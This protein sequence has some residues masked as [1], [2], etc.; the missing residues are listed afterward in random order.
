MRLECRLIKHEEYAEAKRLWAICFPEDGDAFIDYY[1]AKRTDP[2]HIYGAFGGSKMLCMMHI[3]PQLLK[4]NCETKPV[5]LIAGIG[6]L[7]EF[8]RKGVCRELFSHIFS[9]LYKKGYTALL[10]QPF[11]VDFYRQFGFEPFVRHQRVSFSSKAVAPISSPCPLSPGE[12]FSLYSSH[13]VEK[14]P[15]A[16]RRTPEYCSKLIEEFS[17]FGYALRCGDAYALGYGSYVQEL[18]GSLSCKNRLLSHLALKYGMLT[19]PFPYKPGAPSLEVFNMIKVLSKQAFLL[20]TGFSS[21]NE[22]TD[23][24]LSFILDK[25]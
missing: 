24:T 22:L 18:A 4:L 23:P 11:N 2:S 25:Y 7:P 10:L 1:Y 17:T 3:I 13:V 16:V 14:F 5:A 15:I 8:R 19:A 9:E 6:T 12:L 21:I 20:G